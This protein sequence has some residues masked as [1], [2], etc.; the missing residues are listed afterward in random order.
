MRACVR[1]SDTVARVGGDEFVVLLSSIEDSEQSL[2][3][4]EKIRS[5]LEELFNYRPAK[6]LRVTS[7]IGVSLFPDHGASQ[8]DLM[9][10]CD[11][12]MYLA[13]SGGRNSVVLAE[14][15][16]ADRLSEA[17]KIPSSL[18]LI[19]FHWRRAYQTGN[20]II[21]A[22]HHELFNFVNN[23]LKAGLT[24]DTQP[25]KFAESTDEL[26]RHVGQHFAHEEVLLA[27]YGYADLQEHVELHRELMT[28]AEELH[29]KNQIGEA[30]LGDWL[31]FLAN[32]LV[33]GHIL[34]EDRL[35]TTLFK[36]D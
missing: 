22:E 24:I 29:R 32:D 14:L 25:Q 17:A 1:A 11:D 35:Y 19:I 34:R 21:D 8:R 13:K 33:I 36:G 9:K 3:V 18:G 5:A 15:S 26:I 12:A 4:A 31:Q 10:A 2:L 20:A 30:H 6:Q 16:L 28:R 27:E 23:M 7:S